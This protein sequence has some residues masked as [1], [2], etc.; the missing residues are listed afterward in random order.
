MAKIYLT[1]DLLFGRASVAKSRGF[2]SVDH[3]EETLVA[4]WNSVVK[5]NDVVYHVGNFSWDPITAEAAA[6]KLNGKIIFALGEYDSHI[7]ALYSVR[8]GRHF[9]LPS[10]IAVVKDVMMSK[11]RSMRRDMIVCHWPLL[12]WPG[13]DTGT[14]HVH[15]GTM[16]T[17]LT[18][19]R[20]FCVGI[21]MWNMRPIEIGA[22]VEFGE[23]FDRS[24]KKS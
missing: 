24:T 3:M 18:S 14:L 20:R 8:S 2:E 15:G 4:E 1:S 6:S 22:L 16:K 13:R 11:K 19:G 21:E 9:V 23:E 7:P 10:S 5:D 12:D 17:D